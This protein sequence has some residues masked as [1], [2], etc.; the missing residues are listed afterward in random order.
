MTCCSLIQHHEGYTIS[1]PVADM[2][3]RCC[4]P[5]LYPF[6]GSRRTPPSAGPAQHKTS[7]SSSSS[8]T[9]LP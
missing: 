6:S 1:H 9:L 8:A 7:R 2:A 3:L 5:L 4:F